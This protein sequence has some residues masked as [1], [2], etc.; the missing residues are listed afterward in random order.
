MITLEELLSE[1]PEEARIREMNAFQLVAGDFSQ[2]IVLFGAGKL[3]RKIAQT[4][5]LKG[6][7]P[8]GFADNNRGLIGTEVE[9]ITVY[10]PQE[11]VRCFGN[12]A[13]FVVTV[14]HPTVDA[15]MQSR[16]DFLYQL[17][18]KVVTSFLPLAWQ[19]GVVLPHYGVDLPSRLLTHKNELRMIEALLSDGISKRIFHE[20]LMWRLRGDFS[21]IS[22]P[23]AE[24]YFPSDLIAPNEQ[25]AFVDGG[26][27]DGD[28]LRAIPWK[29][30]HA[31][32]VEPDPLNLEKLKRTILSRVTICPFA[33]S[34]EPGAIRFRS[35]GTTAS[36]EDPEGEMVIEAKTLDEI[37]AE[38]CPTFI[39]MDVEG[40]EARALMG[41]KKVISRCQP[42]LAVCIYHGASDFVKIPLLMN[43]LLPQHRIA[44]RSHAH[45]GFELVAYSI[46]SHRFR[47]VLAAL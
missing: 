46:P 38:R 11:A 39:K 6:I 12:R 32:A 29:F 27:F 10:S 33:L 9:G 28:T 19:L 40:C 36:A 47:P 30:E 15:G 3:G 2:S 8:I 45:D 24:Q 44:F 5:L 41:G 21:D 18:C 4:L 7:T 17:G 43:S 22:K 25:E 37:L 23:S 34:N 16:L 42:L 13:V 31:W 14:F 26:A 35:E 20:Q 1:T